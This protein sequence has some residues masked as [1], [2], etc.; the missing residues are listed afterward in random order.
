MGVARRY[1]SGVPKQDARLHE[2]AH[3]IFQKEGIPLGTGDQELF[4]GARRGLSPSRAGNN[5]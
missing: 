4:E 2:A 3:T 1:A 5:S